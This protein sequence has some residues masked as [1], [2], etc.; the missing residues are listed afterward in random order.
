M[1]GLGFILEKSQSLGSVSLMGQNQGLV[2][3]MERGDNLHYLTYAILM[4]GFVPYKSCG[5]ED[6]FFLFR[7]EGVNHQGPGLPPSIGKPPKTGMSHHFL[8]A[9]LGAQCFGVN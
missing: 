7:N 2:H 4:N 8:G 1:K 5:G 6:F 3:K 9:T